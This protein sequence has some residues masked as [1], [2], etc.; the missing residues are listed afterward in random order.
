MRKSFRDKVRDALARKHIQALTPTGKP[1]RKTKAS[2]DVITAEVAFRHFWGKDF[3]KSINWAT[4]KALSD[5]ATS[6]HLGVVYIAGYRLSAQAE[7]KWEV[8]EK[9]ASQ[10]C[11]TVPL[12][13]A[14]GKEI[15]RQVDNG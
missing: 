1:S 9:L 11:D 10:F 15:E 2:V 5:L 4:S 3:Q 7:L 14:S 6:G 12:F 13:T 8:V